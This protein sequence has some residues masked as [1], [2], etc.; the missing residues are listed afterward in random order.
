MTKHTNQAGFGHV[1]A[2]FL[3]LFVA[4]VGFGGYKVATMNKAVGSESSVTLAPKYPKTV[5]TKADLQQT[6]KA[7]DGSNA[8]VSSGLNASALDADLSDLL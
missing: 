3:V 2:V 7:L 8:Q 1:L 6:A 4:V 5:S